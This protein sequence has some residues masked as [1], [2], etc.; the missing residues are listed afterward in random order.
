MGL[1]Y[2][3]LFRS[4]IKSGR[5]KGERKE[6]CRRGRERDIRA[7]RDKSTFFTRSSMSSSFDPL[8]SINRTIN[9]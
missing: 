7:L 3:H 1:I 5:E 4:K 6:M 2:R 8:A 9:I